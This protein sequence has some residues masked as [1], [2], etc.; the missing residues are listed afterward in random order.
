[1]EKMFKYTKNILHRSHKDT[2]CTDVSN[3]KRNTN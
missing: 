3:N 2:L 1:M